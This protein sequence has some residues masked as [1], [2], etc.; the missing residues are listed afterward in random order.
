MEYVWYKRVQVIGWIYNK[1]TIKWEMSLKHSKC[2]MKLRLKHFKNYFGI[3]G[4]KL[5]DFWKLGNDLFRI[6][7]S[8]YFKLHLNN[9]L[10]KSFIGFFWRKIKCLHDMTWFGK[11][12]CV[13]S[14]RL[15]GLVLVF[16]VNVYSLLI[17]SQREI[18]N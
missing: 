2:T 16:C 8:I 11:D 5:R 17:I 15:F 12:S 18:F 10:L 1:L 3:K 14:S 7:S 6:T 13:L 9:V 4:T